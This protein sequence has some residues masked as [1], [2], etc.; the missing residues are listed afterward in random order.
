M[1]NSNTYESFLN[2]AGDK[3]REATKVTVESL[4]DASGQAYGYAKDAA[5][6]VYDYARDASGQAYDYAKD[7]AGQAYDYAKD[8]A[9]YAYDA[10]QSIMDSAK[11][12]LTSAADG[13]NMLL[14]KTS[15]C[16]ADPVQCY[17]GSMLQNAFA[18]F[19]A[20][21]KD[22]GSYIVLNRLLFST[23]LIMSICIFI[24][25]GVH[26]YFR[27]NKFERLGITS[28]TIYGPDGVPI[29]DYEYL[30]DASSYGRGRKSRFSAF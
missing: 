6:Q 20:Q 3:V 28:G 16:I 1:E 10:T 25:L 12:H 21:L 9:D 30:S 14:N 19:T 26:L 2:R 23:I 15:E 8:T 24:Y 22:L 11:E 29:S 17:E 5:D 18:R 7:V 27:L 13:C 4:A